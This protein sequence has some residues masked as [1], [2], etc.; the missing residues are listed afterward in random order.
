MASHQALDLMWTP[1]A[2]LALP[3]PRPAPRINTEGWFLHELLLE[4]RNPLEWVSAAA[5]VVLLLPVLW[6]AGTDAFAARHARGLR[7]LAL[8]AVAPLAL[9][10][11]YL[12]ASGGLRRAVAVVG[13]NDSWT[14]LIGGAVLLLTAYAAYR[15]AARLSGDAAS[16][17]LK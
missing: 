10:G 12:L 11:L 16:I 8:G 1:A 6:P 9:L 15:L 13:W 17:G 3:V 14:N 4:I 7:L 5:L 2:G